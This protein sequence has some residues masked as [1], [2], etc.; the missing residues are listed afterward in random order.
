[1]GRT[2]PA[3]EVHGVVEPDLVLALVDDFSPTALE[4]RGDVVR[5][6]FPTT[7]RR[8]AALQDLR[9]GAVAGTLRVHPVDVDDED[10][11]RRSQ[12][13]LE[14][15]TVGRVTIAP[16]PQPP[17]PRRPA[18]CPEPPTLT[19]VIRPSMGFGTG[20]HATTR[21]CLEALQ[22]FDLK[23]RRVLDV[24]T[25]SGVLA[26][27]AARL[28]AAH[29]LGIDNDS[30]AVTSARENLALNPEASGVEFCECDLRHLRSACETAA[31]RAQSEACLQPP[32]VDVLTANLTG[33]L[34]GREAES[35]K[36]AVAPHG[37]LV[38]SGILATE[39][40]AVLGAFSGLDLLRESAEDEWVC[41]IVK[42]R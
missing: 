19:I 2:W 13:S 7:E 8:D 25:G 16:G 27:A 36:Q 33:A 37:V 3:I 30:D 1:M 28:G 34:L 14:P 18:P 29:V 41:L 39:R 20:H 35:L 42:N 17:A 5:V 9:L 15:V 6:F 22:N 11:A 24:G 10:W 31:L 12:A 40:D 4:E 21:L 23:G 38:L 26:I 32:L